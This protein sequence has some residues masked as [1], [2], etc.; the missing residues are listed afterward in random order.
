V[1]IAIPIPEEWHLW[2]RDEEIPARS[3]EFFPVMNPATGQKLC[4]VAR[5]GAADIDSAVRAA[6]EALP[7]WS[8]MPAAVRGRIM[9]KVALRLRETETELALLETLCNGK[10]LRESR[11]ECRKA[12]EAFEF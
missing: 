12:A 2:I 6:E 1:R 3:E 5:A 10:P 4:Q 8:A 9:L 7:V 11:Q